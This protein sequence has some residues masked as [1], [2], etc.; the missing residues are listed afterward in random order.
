M[1]VKK[2]HPPIDILEINRLRRQLLIQ[3][4]VWDERLVNAARLARHTLPDDPSR[5]ISE[6]EGKSVANGEN[7]ADMNMTVKSGKSYNSCD[8]FLVDGKVNKGFDY[9]VDFD[10]NTDQPNLV[11]LEPSYEGE[12]KSKFSPSTNTCDQSE[13]LESKVNDPTLSEGEFRIRTNLS[14]TLDAA[15]TGENHTGI[16]IMKDNA[17]TFSDLAVVADSSVTSV[18]TERLNLDHTEDQDEPKA[19][20]SFSP[21][22]S[23]KGTENLEDSG[24][25]L[26]VPFLN[27][28]RSLNKNVF[29]SA[30]K[31]NTM[32]EYKPVYVSS[33]RESELQGGARLLL[34]VGENDT[35]ILIYDDEPTSIISYALVS[36]EYRLRLSDEGERLKENVDLMSFSSF[37]DSMSFQSFHSSDDAASESY[38]SYGS[39]EASIFSIS[40]SRSLDPLSYAKALHAR[41]S[42]GE[43]GPLGKVKYSVTCYYAKRFEALRRICC[44]SELDYVR[45]LSRCKKWG[46]QGGKSKV[47]FAKTLDD[48][49][50]IKQVTKTELESFMK[51]AP[52]YFKYL[53]ESI[54]TRS[55]TCLAKILGIYQVIILGS[56]NLL[57]LYC[58][59]QINLTAWSSVITIYTFSNLAAKDLE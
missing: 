29:A 44:P 31:L 4:Y 36:K 6:L 52:E 54:S 17:S 55:P 49:F 27:F 57:R 45:S 30:Q 34:P 48:R 25:W 21:V 43:D 20:Y 3:S 28:Y 7:I 8:S 9:P 39:S 47:F 12:D 32:G 58:N 33:I 18:V 24:S 1:E 22:S 37:S 2:G 46:A 11:H 35:T 59:G 15:W 26:R 16:D 40:G 13:S 50:I 42:F 14:D 5:S 10:S 53:S 56:R 51:F 41:V 19:V 23:T 38:R